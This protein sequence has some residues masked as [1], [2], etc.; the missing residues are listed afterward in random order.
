MD[1]Q[2]QIK[3]IE[4]QILDAHKCFGECQDGTPESRALYSLIQGLEAILQLLKSLAK[5]LQVPPW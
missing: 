5:I 2:S 1:I 4:D 3:S